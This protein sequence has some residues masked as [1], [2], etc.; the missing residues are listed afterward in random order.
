MSFNPTAT[1][2]ALKQLAKDYAGL[3][4]ASY[5]TFAILMEQQQFEDAISGLNDIKQG[6]VQRMEDV[7]ADL[8]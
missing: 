7:F 3:D 6:R 8:D 1:F 4:G 2:S 5:E